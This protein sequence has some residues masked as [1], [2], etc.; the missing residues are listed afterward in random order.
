MNVVR[1][2]IASFALVAT[3]QQALAQMS[4]SDARAEGEAIGTGVRDDTSGTILA[5]GAE[6]NVP[7]FGGT[8]FPTFDYVE[9]PVGLSAAGEAQRYQ[10][11]YQIVVDPYRTTFDPTTLDLSS[12]TAIE[13]DP[14]TFLGTGGGIGGSTGSCSPL[15]PGSGGSITYLESCNAGSQPYDEARTCNAP[16]V[17]QTEG[18]NYWEY[19]CYTEFDRDIARAGNAR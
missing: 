1:L 18:S 19:Q 14:D 2:L 3:G 8:D 10:E 5:T 11:S 15:P 7:T 4:S 9:D 13:Q 16:L 6:E 12:A 17:I